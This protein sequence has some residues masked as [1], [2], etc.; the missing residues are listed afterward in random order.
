MSSVLEKK[1]K[2]ECV[3]A[4]GKTREIDFKSAEP[5][6]LPKFFANKH[7][8]VKTLIV[9]AN[10]AIKHLTSVTCNLCH[11]PGLVPCVSVTHAQRHRATRRPMKSEVT[12]DVDQIDISS[13]HSLCCFNAAMW[14]HSGLSI[15]L[16]QSIVCVADV[17]ITIMWRFL[18]LLY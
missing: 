10:E 3:L 2:K 9:F 5:L 17:L 18:A 1:K 6:G 16:H 4:E 15:I 13:L 7:Q 11:N 8:T 14:D 12:S